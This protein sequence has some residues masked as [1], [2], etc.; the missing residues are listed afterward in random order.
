VN[1]QD[2]GASHQLSFGGGRASRN[3]WQ[4]MVRG[5]HQR[6]PSCGESHM[7]RAFLKVHEHCPTCGEALHHQRADDAPPYFTMFIVAHIVIPL[8]AWVEHSYS[9]NMVAQA[10]AWSAM[11]ILMSLWL[12]PRVK[13]ALVGLQ[14]A[15]YMHGFGGE[16]DAPA[17]EIPEYIER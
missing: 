2:M 7:F 10:V 9:P 5:F 15:N 3:L 16:A 6:C 14:W 1:E 4:S 12:L 13:G 11:S 17:D 8:A